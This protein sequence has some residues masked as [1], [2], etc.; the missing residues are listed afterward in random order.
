M[1]RTKAVL[2]AVSIA[3]LS[4][5]PSNVAQA[6]F[7]QTDPVGYQDQ[8]NLYTYVANDP[9]NLTDPSGNE[10]RNM[11]VAGQIGLGIGVRIEVGY[12][13]GTDA[14][15]DYGLAGEDPGARDGWFVSVGPFLGAAV[16]IEA[17][18]SQC[19]SCSPEDLG[20]SSGWVG[21]DFVAGATFAET[22]KTEQPMPGVGMVANGPGKLVVSASGGPSVG[23]GAG[24]MYT[25]QSP[26]TPEPE[27]AMWM[28][29]V[30]VGIQPIPRDA[31][32]TDDKRELPKQHK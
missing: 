11:F 4:I 27:Q 14:G 5:A 24:A 6:R 15:A 19:I 17:G 16:G 31:P 32:K 3:F 2:R 12:Y 26:N 22:A 20:G 10:A 7:M 9:L 29:P 23:G 21:G 18:G 25:F 28:P 13:N 1:T 30:E 8:T